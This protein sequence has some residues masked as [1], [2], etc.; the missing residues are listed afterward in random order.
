MT[1]PP[2]TEQSGRWRAVRRGG[3]V[4]YAQFERTHIECRGCCQLRERKR[5]RGR[6]VASISIL[7]KD[8]PIPSKGVSDP[9]ADRPADETFIDRFVGASGGVVKRS[10]Q[11]RPHELVV[12]PGK[13]A[14]CVIQ[15]IVGGIADP[16]ADRFAVKDR[17]LI[18]ADAGDI[19]DRR[20]PGAARRHIAHYAQHQAKREHVVEAE[21]NAAAPLRRV[22]ARSGKRRSGHVVDGAVVALQRA[23]IDAPT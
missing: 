23:A 11:L 7:G 10:G 19:R 4:V 8:V 21:L 1:A 9:A 15:D 13:A 12:G 18:G 3:F 2:D 16:S 14:C 17:G 5:D 20:G 22:P 6:A